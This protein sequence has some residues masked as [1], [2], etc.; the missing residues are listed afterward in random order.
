MALELEMMCIRDPLWYRFKDMPECGTCCH[1][2]TRRILENYFLVFLVSNLLFCFHM[3]VTFPFITLFVVFVVCFKQYL[4]PN[5][6][7]E[8]K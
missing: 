4:F 5:G 7:F 2:C 1:L 3:S 8:V 6:S